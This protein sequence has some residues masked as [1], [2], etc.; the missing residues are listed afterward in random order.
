MQHVA[1]E[2]VAVLVGDVPHDHRAAPHVALI[3]AIAHA[4]AHILEVCVAQP[5]RVGRRVLRVALPLHPRRH[6]RRRRRRRARRHIVGRTRGRPRHEMLR[7]DLELG[8]RTV[9]RHGECVDRIV[10]VAVPVG[11]LA[12][13]HA[14]VGRE[15]LD[16]VVLPRGEDDALLE[17]GR[18]DRLSR[19]SVPAERRRVAVVK[20]E[21][22]A[23][24]LRNRLHGEEAAFAV[25]I[26]RVGRRAA[27]S[28]TSNV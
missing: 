3:L 21:R 6:R 26:L 2:H 8:D 9:R 7:L 19:R 11:D 16:V 28:R 22:D 1:R 14:E 27:A 24:E 4:G 18:L 10:I 13:G 12:L 5:H 20:V 17:R 15:E 25:G 23:E